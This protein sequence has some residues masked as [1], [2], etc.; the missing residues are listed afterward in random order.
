MNLPIVIDPMICHGQPIIAGTRTPVAVILDAL[1]GGDS[2]ELLC[3]EYDLT[4]E[5]I[6]ACIAFAS[7]Q[8]KTQHYLP[9]PA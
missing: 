2:H 8:I 1:A 6:R 7:E 4:D 9:I 3:R 5:D